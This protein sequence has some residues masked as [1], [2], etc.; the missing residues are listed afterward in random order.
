MNF[1]RLRWVV[2]LPE[3]ATAVSG[4]KR[5]FASDG[6]GGERGQCRPRFHL[7]RGLLSVLVEQFVDQRDVGVD[8]RV[9]QAL[10]LC[11]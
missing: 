4:A 7:G 8:H 6:T 1:K 2:S 10:L 5:P 11:D 3:H 9:A